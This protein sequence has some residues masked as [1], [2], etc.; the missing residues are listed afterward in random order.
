M[1]ARVFLERHVLPPI[2]MHMSH[3]KCT[4]YHIII[5]ILLWNDDLINGGKWSEEMEDKDLTS[6]PVVGL[7]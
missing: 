6:W 7:T 2:Y 5:S 4:A 3:W 1:N